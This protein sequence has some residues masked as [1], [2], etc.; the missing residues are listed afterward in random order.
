MIVSGFL[1]PCSGVSQ[2][3]IL[4]CWTQVAVGHHAASNAEA[5]AANRKAAIA[6]FRAK[7]KQRNFEKKVRYASRQRLAETRPRVRG[8]FVKAEQYAAHV[9]AGE[10]S[11][12][13]PAAVPTA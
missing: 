11:A 12:P 1:Y 13:A 7:R 10:A 4:S 5:C 9:A 2:S 3:D 8:Q 6:K